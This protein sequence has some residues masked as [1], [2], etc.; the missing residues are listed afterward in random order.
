MEKTAKQRIIESVREVMP[1]TVKTCFWLIKI[2]VGI[3]ILILF[4]RYFNILPWFSELI[5]PVNF[6][7]VLINDIYNSLA[8]RTRVE[9][10]KI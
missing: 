2:T 7:F 3:S 1:K 5:S 10:I 9:V 8:I 4:L 6:N